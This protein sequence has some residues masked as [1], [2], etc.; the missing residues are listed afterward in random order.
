[1]NSYSRNRYS[2]NRAPSR[3]SNT[4]LNSFDP[5]YPETPEFFDYDY[6]VNVGSNGNDFGSNLGSRGT[7]LPTGILPER[8]VGLA[9][10]RSRKARLWR[11]VY[12]L[13]YLRELYRR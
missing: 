13:Q 12:Y 6:D 2:N 5:I 8:A 4:A 1:L 9:N 11:K 7:P 10:S 3:Q